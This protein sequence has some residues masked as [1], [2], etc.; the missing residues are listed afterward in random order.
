MSRRDIVV[1]VRESDTRLE[2]YHSVLLSRA[3]HTIQTDPGH[4][5]GG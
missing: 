1:R 4:L 5:V 3:I 2:I